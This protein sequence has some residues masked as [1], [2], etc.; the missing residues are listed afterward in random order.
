MPAIAAKRRRQADVTD[1]PEL[2]LAIR[3]GDSTAKVVGRSAEGAMA[4]E[5]RLASHVNSSLTL[6]REGSAP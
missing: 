3:V 2:R 5:L 1:N 6:S 4:G